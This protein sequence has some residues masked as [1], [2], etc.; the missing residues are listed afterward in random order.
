[1]I[2]AVTV[3]VSVRIALLAVLRAANC[4]LAAWRICQCQAPMLMRKLMLARPRSM[5]TV[6]RDLA[7]LC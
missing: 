4:E 1:M 5:E 2:L 7:L 3:L 6:K